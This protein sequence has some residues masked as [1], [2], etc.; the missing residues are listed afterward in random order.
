MQAVFSPIDAF[1][2]SALTSCYIL[3]TTSHA[4]MHVPSFV[5]PA[6]ATNGLRPVL[7]APCC[8]RRPPTPPRYHGDVS[9]GRHAHHGD[10]PAGLTP[11]A[12]PPGASL[13]RPR[14]RAAS[15]RWRCFQRVRAPQRPQL[16]PARAPGPGMPLTPQPHC[17]PARAGAAR[18]WPQ[19]SDVQ[20][21]GR[22]GCVGDHPHHARPPV[23]AQDAP[24]PDGRH[25]HDQRRQLDLA[26][27][28]RLPPGSQVDD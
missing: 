7:R 13:F 23:D 1:S 25:R 28:R 6:R 22:Q 24:G 19:G 17:C 4:R 10:E 8:E 3:R 16:W 15:S 14:A 12:P 5:F 9:N 18:D 20:H 11:S 27:S 2:T 21:C 26:R